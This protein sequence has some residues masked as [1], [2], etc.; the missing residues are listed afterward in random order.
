MNTPFYS[1]IDVEVS[2]APEQGPEYTISFMN[3]LENDR[4]LLHFDLAFEA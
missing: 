1:F 4:S 3:D 2:K